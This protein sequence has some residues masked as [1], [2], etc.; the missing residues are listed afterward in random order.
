M[1]PEGSDAVERQTVSG[2]CTPED[3]ALR[4]QAWNWVKG[5]G[6]SWDRSRVPFLYWSA[7]AESFWPAGATVLGRRV[8]FGLDEVGLEMGRRR[9]RRRGKGHAREAYRLACL[10]L[11]AE[12]SGGTR[13]T[14]CGFGAG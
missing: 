14:F 1:L 6:E 9:G 7:W 12:R 13:W 5:E 8:S 10:S 2:W 3:W 4:N 11:A